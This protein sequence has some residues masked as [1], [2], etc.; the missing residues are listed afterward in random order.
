[1]NSTCSAILSDQPVVNVL[2]PTN[3][4]VTLEDANICANNPISV[5][6]ENS[7][8]D[9]IYRIF[10]ITNSEVFSEDFIGNG[11]DLVLT[12]YL[13][14]DTIDIEVTGELGSCNVSF[15]SAKIEPRGTPE[16]TITDAG[17]I[18]TASKGESYQWYLDG[19]II[20]GANKQEYSPRE[21]GDYTV[22]VTSN[23]CS[24]VSEPFSA[25]VLGL[26]DLIKS[27]E[28]S[29]F[30]N[31]TSGVLNIKQDGRF[32]RLTIYNLMGQVIVTK[33]IVFQNEVVMLSFLQP[34]QYILELTG[35]SE[36]VKVNIQK[37][38]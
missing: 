38:K 34:G 14:T 37:H 30:P 36:S 4:K 15:T 11:K 9:V 28:L 21:L 7:E 31:P 23:G 16:S 17:G 25:T 26:E 2:P 8:T 29:V 27:G 3:R 35:K 22:K 32:N 12:S 24:V 19:K 33:D 1:M 18:L 13:V 5:T 20:L 10:N 6:V